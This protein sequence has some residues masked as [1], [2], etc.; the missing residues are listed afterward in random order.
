MK[1]ILSKIEEAKQLRGKILIRG[2]KEKLQGKLKN[3]YYI[4]PTIIEGLSSD[5]DINQE[6]I[7]GPV[8]S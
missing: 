5:C 3:G 7:F 1:K 4:Q 8:V 6:K 2:E